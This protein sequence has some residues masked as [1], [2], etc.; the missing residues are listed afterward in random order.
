MAIGPA[1]SSVGQPHATATACARALVRF[2]GSLLIVPVLAH[3]AAVAVNVR[4]TGRMKN[5]AKRSCVRRIRHRFVT[6]LF[7]IR[8]PV[9][10]R[11]L[12][13]KA[14]T[15]T[16]PASRANKGGRRARPWPT[17][18]GW[19]AASLRGEE[20]RQCRNHAAHLRPCCCANACFT[21]A[22]ASRR[23]GLA[24]SGEI[25]RPNSTLHADEGESSRS[26]MRPSVSGRTWNCATSWRPARRPPQL[27][28]AS[29]TPAH[30]RLP[31][32]GLP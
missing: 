16:V 28:L 32:R 15:A 12:R 24:G 21:A 17:L 10:H 14:A 8:H 1:A 23:D 18:G 9:R 4:S 30:S 20:M 13:S 2:L 7:V 6:N 29:A 3:S 19:P 26:T 31:K 11:V 5:P 25:G 27:E 22:S